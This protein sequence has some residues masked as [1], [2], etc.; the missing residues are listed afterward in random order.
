MKIRHLE[1]ELFDTD[2]SRVDRHHELT[3]GFRTSQKLVRTNGVHEIIILCT[4]L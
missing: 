1:T 4:K 3:V 2:V